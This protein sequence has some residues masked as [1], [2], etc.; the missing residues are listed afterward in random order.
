MTEPKL[1]SEAEQGKDSLV[2]EISNHG[3]TIPKERLERIFE[4]FYRLDSER[5]SGGTGL[6]LAIA[7]Q[8]V[9]LHKGAITAESENERTVFTVTLPVL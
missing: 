5:R 2:T 8:I 3:G 4:Q 7:R 6:G 1:S 9:T